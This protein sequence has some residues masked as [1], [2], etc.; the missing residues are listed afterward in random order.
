[1]IK[2]SFRSTNTVD[3][4]C[5]ILETS[6][7]NQMEIDQWLMEKVQT[8]KFDSMDFPHDLDS[9]YDCYFSSE[10]ED[11]DAHKIYHLLVCSL[12]GIKQVLFSVYIVDNRMNQI[13]EIGIL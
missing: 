8:I 1:M 11:N 12:V 4:V 10:Q 13:S 3:D 2:V 6:L 7:T 9:F 5:D